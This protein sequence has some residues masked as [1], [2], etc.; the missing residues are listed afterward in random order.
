MELAS[1]DRELTALPARPRSEP[2][3]SR[4][5][6]ALSSGTTD[7][8]STGRSLSKAEMAPSWHGSLPIADTAGHAARRAARERSPAACAR[9]LSDSEAPRGSAPSAH[10][11]LAA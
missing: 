6:R 8:T 10:P 1:D 2:T 4:R 9:R 11:V 7:L 3:A 5:D